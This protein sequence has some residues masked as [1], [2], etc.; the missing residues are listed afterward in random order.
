MFASKIVKA[1]NALKMM[2]NGGG[3]K[4]TEK[5]R[6]E[7]YK[8]LAWYSKKAITNIICLKNL[9]KCYQVTY[10]SEVNKTFVVHCSAFGLDDLLF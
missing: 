8:Y 10:D 6:I 2:S 7:G 3:L 5:C 9:I 4:I 1:A